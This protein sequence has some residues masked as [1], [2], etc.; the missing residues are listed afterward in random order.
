MHARYIS[1]TLVI[2]ILFDRFIPQALA[3]V[4]DLAA[5]YSSDGVDVHFLNNSRSAVDIKVSLFNIYI[6]LC[7]HRLP[8]T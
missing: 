7:S 6:F 1:L 5:K 3:G 4:A 2:F 8:W